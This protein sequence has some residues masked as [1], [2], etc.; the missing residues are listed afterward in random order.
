MRDEVYIVGTGGFAA[1]VTEYISDNNKIEKTQISILGYF[2]LDDSH[3]QKYNLVAPYLG[4]EKDHNFT[5]ND[6][7]IVAIGNSDIR[8]QVL[9]H[10]IQKGIKFYTFIHHSCFVSSTSSIGEGNILCPNVMIGPKTE[11]GNHNIFNYNTAVPHDCQIGHF[12]IFAPYVQLTGY[13]SVGSENLFGTSMVVTP[14]VKIEN[15]N[16]F[17]ANIVVQ[18][19]VMSNNLVVVVQKTT[20]VPRPTFRSI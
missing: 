20:K 9:A 15:N 7:V 10:L 3:H 14:S 1:E 4:N 6:K 5:K 17:Q 2:D 18:R 16:S 8:K 11:V 13:V 12:N 19:N